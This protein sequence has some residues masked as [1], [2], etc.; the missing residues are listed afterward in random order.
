MLGEER[1]W[2]NDNRLY[3][4]GDE[5]TDS[6]SRQRQKRGIEKR[7]KKRAFFLLCASVSYVVKPK[8]C[9]RIERRGERSM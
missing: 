5:L 3:S 8:V 4:Y 1:R 9:C 2:T 7:R 6:E